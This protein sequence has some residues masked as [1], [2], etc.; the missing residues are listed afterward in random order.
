MH[1]LP[2]SESTRPSAQS[3]LWHPGADRLR[4]ASTLLLVTLASLLLACAHAEA[5]Q[6]TDA[7]AQASGDLP[8]LDAR[9]STYAYPYP[10]QQL[11]LTTQGQQLELS[12]MDVPAQGEA[13]GET[14]L[15][16]HGKNFSGAYWAPTVRALTEAGHR[17]VVPDQIGFGKSSKPAHFQYSF[18]ALAT[19]TLALLDSLGVE[20]VVV[21][22][23]SMGGMLAVRLALMAPERVVRLALVN[24]IGLEDWKREQVPYTPI[25]VSYAAELKQTPDTLRAYMQASYFDGTWKPD[26]EPLVEILGGWTRGPDRERI[27]W[28]AALTSDM[29]FTQPVLYEFEDLR[30][31]TLLIIGQRDRTAIGRAAAPPDVRERLGQ[32]PVLGR[33]AAAAIPGAR[34]IELEGIGHMPQVEDFDGYLQA[35]LPFIQGR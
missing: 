8:G 2:G 15:L 13:R 9:L 19:H 25:D 31:P 29:V 14:V 17:V 30:V 28:T 32:Y 1:A 27:A 35:L 23:H 5:P 21:V 10:V 26:Y 22:G 11:P 3:V 12:Y 24:P 33:R 6:K 34:L 20:R 4:H 16:L 7:T 18:Q